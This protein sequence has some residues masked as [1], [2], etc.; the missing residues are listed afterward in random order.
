MSDNLLEV[1]A[2]ALNADQRFITEG[3]HA[4][5]WP[6]LRETHVCRHD[7]GDPRPY[8]VADIRFYGGNTRLLMRGYGQL[9]HLSR[10]LNDPEADPVEF[11]IQKLAKYH[12]KHKSNC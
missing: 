2:I 4:T 3:L 8:T 12:P 1:L 5:Y 6:S 11:V 10:S 9:H 7:E